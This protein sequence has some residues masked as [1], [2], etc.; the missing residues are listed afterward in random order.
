MYR[1]IP[2]MREMSL[3]L[4]PIKTVCQGCRSVFMYCA[5]LIKATVPSASLTCSPTIA[6]SRLKSE[7]WFS[8]PFFCSLNSLRVR[9]LR[10]I[11]CSLFLRSVLIASSRASLRL[12]SRRMSEICPLRESRSRV[13]VLRSASGDGL[14]QAGNT[15]DA[16]PKR[17]A[18]TASGP[19]TRGI[20]RCCMAEIIRPAR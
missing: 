13:S 2:V 5:R 17:A 20:K 9:L 7:S 3:G 16:A 12:M 14:L 18:H 11:A 10:L 6:A 4:P 8:T 19:N 1:S 15:A